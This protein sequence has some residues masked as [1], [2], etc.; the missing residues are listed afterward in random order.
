MQSRNRT[1][2]NFFI[3]LPSDPL[4]IIIG[5]LLGEVNKSQG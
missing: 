1:L 4:V 3:I 5:A 2:K